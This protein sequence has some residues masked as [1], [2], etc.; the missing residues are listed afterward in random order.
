MRAALSR[1]GSA[2]G[3]ATLAVI[4]G[5]GLSV[6]TSSGR[7]AV[8]RASAH[9]MA[10]SQ[11]L[12]TTVQ[13]TA[14]CT[15][16]SGSPTSSADCGGG[17]DDE[18]GD[19]GNGSLYRTM[20]SFAGGLGI[21]AGSHI[22]SSTLTIDVAGAFG[23]TPSWVFQMT[24]A[25]SPG[26]ATWDAYDGVNAWSTAGG[27]Y[28]DSLQA[29]STVTG[30]GAVSFTITPMT[31]AWLDGTAPT[32]ELMILP[33]TGAGNAFSFANQASGNGPYLTVAYQPPSTSARRRRPHPSSR[34]RSAR[35][36][37]RPPRDGRSRSSSCSAGP[38]TGRRSG[39]TG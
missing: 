2:A 31:Q 4:V 38:G 7:A 35:R 39:C 1:R 10:A 17:S 28:N 27:D 13:P 24:R 15:I 37:R 14:D 22:L 33:Y 16:Y 11:S 30:P 12:S 23:S 20:I 6:A 5:A 34:R 8:A 32:P 3:G 25:F 29:S 18:V 19:D 9:P 36:C 21:P 26:A